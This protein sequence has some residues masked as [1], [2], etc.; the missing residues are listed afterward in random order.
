MDQ[1]F[2]HHTLDGFFDENS[3]IQLSVNPLPLSWDHKKRSS[4]TLSSES[5]S[6]VS[7]WK[8]IEDLFA[9]TASYCHC[10]LLFGTKNLHHQQRSNHDEVSI[11]QESFA[12]Q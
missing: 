8:A 5:S 11:C 12:S 6:H 3:V 10:R 2:G 7:Y 1:L 4:S 9:A